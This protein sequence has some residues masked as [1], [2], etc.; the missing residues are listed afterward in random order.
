MNPPQIIP[1][2]APSNALVPFSDSKQVTSPANTSYGRSRGGGPVMDD[3]PLPNLMSNKHN[4]A[5]SQLVGQTPN[6]NK[7]GRLKEQ[8]NGAITPEN[9]YG[10]ERQIIASHIPAPNYDAQYL[11]RLLF[12]KAA[13]D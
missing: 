7:V 6:S 11:K 8:S 12:I 9:A 1:I 10:G 3:I 13:I 2:T 5:H 4:R